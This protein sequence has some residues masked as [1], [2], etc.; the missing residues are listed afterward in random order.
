LAPQAALVA[1]IVFRKQDIEHHAE[2]PRSFLRKRQ[3][4]SRSDFREVMLFCI[5]DH[6][7]IDWIKKRFEPHVH[8]PFLLIVGVGAQRNDQEGGILTNCTFNGPLLISLQLWLG[9]MILV[10][11]GVEDRA[12]SPVT[13][14]TDEER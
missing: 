8:L 5:P 10:A 6:P 3:Q 14:H 2:C 1:C 4:I 13:F 11:I 12:S 7:I 9:L